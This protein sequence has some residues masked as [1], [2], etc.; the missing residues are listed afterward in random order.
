MSGLHRLVK[1]V[2]GNVRGRAGEGSVAEPFLVGCGIEL[3][4][5]L[6]TLTKYVVPNAIC[7]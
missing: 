2:F 5:K 4:R 3:E 1:C 7:L 6:I